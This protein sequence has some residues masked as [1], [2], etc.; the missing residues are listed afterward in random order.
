MPSLLWQTTMAA[1]NRI[2]ASLINQSFPISPVA[3][4][5]ISNVFSISFTAA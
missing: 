1:R 3:S 2:K 4:A 5:I